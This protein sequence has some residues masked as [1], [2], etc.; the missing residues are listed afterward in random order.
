MIQ[1]VHIL[2]HQPGLHHQLCRHVQLGHQAPHPQ[3]LFAH[4]LDMKEGQEVAKEVRQEV[5]KAVRRAKVHQAKVHQANQRQEVHRVEQ[6]DRAAGGQ[7]GQLE[8]LVH[9]DTPEEVVHQDKLDTIIHQ[10]QLEI[11]IHHDGTKELNKLKLYA[12]H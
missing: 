5:V 3:V 12:H 11:N 7:Q 9:Q 6:A 4:I 8:E 1:T 10:G 2:V